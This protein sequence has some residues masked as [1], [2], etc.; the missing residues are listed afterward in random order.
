MI[1]SLRSRGKSLPWLAPS[2]GILCFLYLLPLA[3]VLVISILE[4]NFGFANYE[5]LVLDD[6]LRRVF[7][8]TFRISGITTIVSVFLGYIVAFVMVKS[9]LRQFRTMAVCVLVPFWISVLVRAFA[10]VVLLRSGGV[11]NSALIG[12]GI[13][14]QPLDLV[15]NDFGV[16]VGMVHYMVPL[17]VLTL[18]GQMS[19]IDVRLTMA[20]RG[21]GAGPWYAFRRAFLPLSVPGIAAAAILV[22]ISALGFYITP[23]ML[24]GGKTLMLAEYVSVT[25]SSTVN[26]GLGTAMAS[27]LAFLVLLLL[28]IL[29][30]IVDL[31]RV[32]GG[33]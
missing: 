33:A 9:T 20:A 29:S 15:Y 11:V 5:K 1:G 24:G 12:M 2:V 10:W 32:F 27:T 14:S 7:W 6:G 18:Y 17:A 31:R 8:T 13:I 30:R 19:G 21:L 16:I 3:K 22:F 4:P 26:W 25:I 23:A 28:F